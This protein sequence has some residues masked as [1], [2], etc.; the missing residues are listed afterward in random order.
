MRFKHLPLSKSTV[1]QNPEVLAD[2]YS[3]ILYI[4]SE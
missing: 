2:A 4:V 3:T 1:F